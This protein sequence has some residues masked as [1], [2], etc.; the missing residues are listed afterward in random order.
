MKYF[1]KGIFLKEI[2]CLRILYEQLFC[3]G[4]NFSVSRTDEQNEAMS[5]ISGRTYL[6]P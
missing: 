4:N 5:K 3:L 6:S 1:L 2:I